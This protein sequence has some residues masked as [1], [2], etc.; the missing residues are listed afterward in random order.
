MINNNQVKLKINLSL[1]IRKIR[2]DTQKK[3]KIAILNII[4]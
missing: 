3:T 4:Y 2:S 1:N